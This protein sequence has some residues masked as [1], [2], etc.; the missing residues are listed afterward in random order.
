MLTTAK[1]FKTGH[2]QAVRLPKEF[3]LPGDE[4][5]I[6]RNEATG[7]VILT[8]LSPVSR[9][10]RLD[11]LFKMLDEAPVPEEFM[12]ERD[13]EPGQFRNIF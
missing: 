1:L 9:K 12:A 3:R 7:E 4:V 6:R 10:D 2:S 13:N 11:R 5:L 8:P